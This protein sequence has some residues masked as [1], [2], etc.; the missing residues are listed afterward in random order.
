MEKVIIMIGPPGSGKG[1]QAKKIA[2]KYNYEH[3]STGDLLR[4]L[5]KSPE[6]SLK[7]KN[8]LDEVLKEGELAPDDLIYRLTFAQIIKDLKNKD[9]VVLDGAIRNL[10][11]AG[12]FQKFFQE[13]KLSVLVFHVSLT[14]K[15]IFARLAKRKLLE[16]RQDDEQKVVEERV[17]TQ[18]TKA[19]APILNFYKDKG[20]LAEVDGS[21]SI[22]EVEKSIDKILA[23]RK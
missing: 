8:I 17:K 22:A 23:G 13:N 2:E 9:G 6:I 19:L 1:T 3:I 14:D 16:N 10:K 12:D 18:G 20:L 21:P 11:Q 15:E 5:Y 4:S 7:E